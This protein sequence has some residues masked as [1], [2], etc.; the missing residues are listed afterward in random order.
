MYYK[1][2]LIYLI[3][4][5]IVAVIITIYDKISAIN[6]NRRISENFLMFLA[7]T[8]GSV[9][10]FF[11]MLVSRHKSKHAKFMYGIPL[12]IIIQLTAIAVV[13]EYI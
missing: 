1:Y 4:I 7:L 9:A 6:H 12:I 5:N 11:T 13:S 8:G 10:M 3:I 2:V